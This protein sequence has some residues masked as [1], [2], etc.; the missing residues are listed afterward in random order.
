MTPCELSMGHYHSLILSQSIFP[1]HKKNCSAC[2]LDIALGNNCVVVY[3]KPRRMCLREGPEVNLKKIKR[4]RQ[5]LRLI[6]ISKTTL[7]ML[8][9]PSRKGL[10]LTEDS[11]DYYPTARDKWRLNEER[12][13]ITI[14]HALVV[15]GGKLEWQ[16]HTLSVTMQCCTW[17]R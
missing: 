12:R 6:Y 4:R 10:W 16:P 11:P 17:F 14:M 13:A 5:V 8:M 3:S 1:L 2:D 15:S 9:C 7:P